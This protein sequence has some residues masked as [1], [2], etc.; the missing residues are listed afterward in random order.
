ME[1]KENKD[2]ENKKTYSEMTPSEKY[3]RK[4]QVLRYVGYNGMNLK[5]VDKE[6]RNDKDVV[7]AAISNNGNAINYVSL[8]L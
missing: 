3:I 5:N 8:D 4:R 7:K 1:E 2:N 6:L